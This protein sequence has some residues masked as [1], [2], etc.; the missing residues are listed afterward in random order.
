MQSPRFTLSKALSTFM[1][2]LKGSPMKIVQASCMVA[3]TLCLAGVALADDLQ[4]VGDPESLGFSARRLERITSWFEAQSEKG[5]PSGFVVA[6]ARGGK[7][8]YL[9]PTGFEDHDK[10]IP[11]R[12]DSI[13]R[14]GSMSKQI[15]SVATMMLVDEGKLDLDAPVA[16]YLPELRDMQVVK[17]DPATGDAT[18]GEI[19]PAKRAMTIRDLLRNTSG[20]VYAG[21][22]YADPGFGNAAIHALYG[23]KAPFR[24]DKP[25][26]PFVASLGTLPLLHQPGEV[27]E[28]SLGFDV[29]G[30]VIEVVSGETFDQFLQSRLFAPLH[31][32]DSG[33]S[34]PADKLARL[35][36]V[37][38]AQPAPLSDGDVAKPQT[39]FS[40]GGGIVSTVP[41]FL[42]FCQ[43]LLNGGQLD[44]ARILKPETV[45][46][47]MT[48]S[49]PPDIHIA[50]HEAGP[51]F[52]TGWGL[53]FA[54]R[55]NP[56]FSLI[57][58]A[59]GSFNWQGSWG[60][61]FSVDPAQ[62]LILVMMMQRRQY[63]EN[64]FYFNAIRRLPYAALKVP[65]APAPPA[66]APLKSAALTEYVGR[67]DFGGSASSLDR[68]TSVADANGWTGLES[69]VGETDGLRVVKPAD[70]GP[71]ARAGVMAG[72]LITAIGDR[73]IKG[74]TLEAAFRR[75]SGPVNA[76]IK[77]K[78]SRRAQNDPLVVAF[79][80]EPVPSHSVE[81]QIRVAD[82]KVVVEATGGWS[83]LDFDKGQPTSVAARSRDEFQV[84]S[85]DQTRIA[86]I[87]DPA[88]KVNGA[89]LNPGPW[90]Q[91]GTLAQEGAH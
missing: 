49:L 52:G 3:L 31:M 30:R 27:W 33:F 47:M 58:G 39:F 44:G 19:E 83:I 43:M 55:T 90:E 91:Q 37:P 67:Y 24:R 45:R 4:T 42:R 38:G 36:A 70:A 59:V 23:V 40:G 53:G 41:D 78:I 13:F 60:T 68:Q 29:L 32:V 85:D 75:I 6:I 8:A 2:R 16:Q 48:N 34:V 35:V 5:D 54:I 7:L 18:L 56:D 71:A 87:R 9:Q 22:D 86:F 15:T 57:P 82:G 76:T 51:A 46:L 66:S 88:G 21:P 63:S 20:L 89:V 74:L 17:K 10:K 84:E 81:L 80:R 73:S 28:Y 1:L 11:M 65:E 61:F 72:D 77:L 62:K 79:A 12:P 69:V 25:I 26:A 50:G 64:G 14:I